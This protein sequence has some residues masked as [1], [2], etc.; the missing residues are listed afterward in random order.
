M[1]IAAANCDLPLGA[2]PV[3]AGQ[4]EQRSEAGLAS[5]RT[6]RGEVYCAPWRFDVPSPP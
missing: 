1:K 3:D 4:N 2:L 5:S 6:L